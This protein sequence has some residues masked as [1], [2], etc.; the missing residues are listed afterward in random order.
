MTNPTEGA[1]P[2]AFNKW[3]A[4]RISWLGQERRSG[5]DY[6]YLTLKMEECQYIAKKFADLQSPR[7]RKQN[8]DG[9]MDADTSL[10]GGLSP[11]VT[12]VQPEHR[13]DTPQSPQAA[14]GRERA[15]RYKPE[16]NANGRWIVTETEDDSGL[17]FGAKIYAD[18]YAAAM[19]GGKNVR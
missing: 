18:E 19:N 15:L 6:Q 10:H 2:D 7:T 3:L 11:K 9:V 5:G 8:S 4:D 17:T 1:M 16:R 14:S 13:P 12:R